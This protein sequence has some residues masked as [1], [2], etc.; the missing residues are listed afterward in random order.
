MLKEQ[1]LRLPAF[2]KDAGVVH[3]HRV[4]IKLIR[5]S[6]MLASAIINRSSTYVIKMPVLE[7]P[8]NL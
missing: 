8:K 5:W 3:F 4:L 2:L 1:K 7:S 6:E